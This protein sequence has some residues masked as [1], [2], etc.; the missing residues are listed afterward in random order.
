[1]RRIIAGVVIVI[2]IVLILIGVSSCSSSANKSSLENYNSNVNSLI[3][4]SQSDS[5]KLFSALNGGVST[6]TATSVQNQINTIAQDASSVLSSA[7]KQSTPSQM[8]LAQTNLVQALQF[9][10]DG[11]NSIA[12][13]LQPAVGSSGAQVSSSAV[14]TIAGELGGATASASVLVRGATLWVK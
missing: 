13:S 6:A 12:R 4:R 14:S 8:K 2:V 10:Y 3:K 9:R 1:M 5:S 7:Q 11:I